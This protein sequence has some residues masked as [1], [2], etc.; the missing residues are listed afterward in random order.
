MFD[1]QYYR[2][3]AKKE[4]FE[5]SLSNAFSRKN[6]HNIVRRGKQ[7]YDNFMEKNSN[8]ICF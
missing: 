2:E 4:K 5:N 7:E 8:E 6:V 1:L 3:L